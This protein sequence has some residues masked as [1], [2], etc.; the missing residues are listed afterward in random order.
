MIS[1]SRV[2]WSEHRACVREWFTLKC[3]SIHLVY[4]GL[5]C[6]SETHI[7]TR[8][9]FPSRTEPLLWYRYS[10]SR[11]GCFERSGAGLED[12]RDPLHSSMPASRAGTLSA[13]FRKWSKKMLMGSPTP[14]IQTMPLW[15][16]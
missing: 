2:V 3:Y 11:Y 7:H 12:S 10:L 1:K 14:T 8:L 16:A 15:R 4:L 13:H 5:S 6:C 9:F